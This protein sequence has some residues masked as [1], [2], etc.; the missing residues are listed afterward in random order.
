M[1]KLDMDLYENYEEFFYLTAPKAIYYRTIIRY[2]YKELQR[3][4]FLYR[5]EIYQYMLQFEEFKGYSEDD[6][7]KDLDILSEKGNI[8]KYKNDYSAIKSL[9][10]IKKKKY[11]YQLTEKTRMIEELLINRF[12]EINAITVVLDRNLLK[13]F[14]K[15]LR[16]FLDSKEEF[17][18]NSHR[19]I[20]Y[21]WNSIA[22]AFQE[23]N[24]NYITYIQDISSFEYEKM[25]DADSFREKKGKLKEY[26]EEF[27]TALIEESDEIKE[28]LLKLEETKEFQELIEIVI[29]QEYEQRSMQKEIKKNSARESI[30]NQKSKIFNW[31]V[32]IDGNNE[33]EN[34]KQNSINVINKIIKLAKK[35]IAK[36]LINYSRK[37]S[38]KKT[39]KLFAECGSIEEGHKFGAILFGIEQVYH[40]KGEKNVVEPGEVIETAEDSSLE[41]TL[42]KL[43]DIS[44]G[45]GKVGI[46]DRTIEKKNRIM[47]LEIERENKKNEISKY[48]LD[49]KIEIEKLPQVTSEIKNIIVEYIKKG[50]AKPKSKDKKMIIIDD[51]MY[52]E[53]NETEYNGQKYRLLF[54]ETE[55]T[56]LRCEDGNLDMPSFVLIFS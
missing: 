40:L 8:L 14:K 4:E 6:C 10:E 21:W 43:S 23:L 42:K 20:Y 51:K 48:I 28:I 38:Y 25:A 15:E 16:K 30:L 31:F 17:L 33:V 47:Q 39:A 29:E 54:P 22:R 7:H 27:I 56:V 53:Y 36:S 52:I 50:M 55:R 45:T 44:K 18:Q 41:I 5:Y 2:I 1:E 26:L 35:F 46:I 32:G 37:E 24:R 49:G 34:L 19:D 3:R 12:N 9:D 13:N 11:R